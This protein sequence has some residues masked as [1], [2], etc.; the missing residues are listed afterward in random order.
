S[1]PEIDG[2]RG[3]FARL[4]A[5]VKEIRKEKE[6]AGKEVLLL[7]AGDFLGGSP[8][9]WLSL[10]GEAAELKLMQK[11]GYQAAVMGNHEFDYGPELL[12]EYLKEAGYPDAHSDLS[13]LASNLEAPADSLF[14]EDN[15][16]R[17]KRIIE[18]D[19][20]L[21]IGILGIQGENSVSMI[22]D[23][24]DLTF[25]NSVKT[26]QKMTA[27][28][29]K[30][31]DVIIA[32]THSGIREDLKLAREIPALD[33][34]IGGHSHTRLDEVIETDETLIAQAGSKLEYLGQLDL[35]YDLEAEELKL[36]K[37][38]S[39]L[40]ELN[41]E[42][43]ADPEMKT[44]IDDYKDQFNNQIAEITEYQHY[45]EP[46]T[47]SDF[48]IQAGPPLSESPAG[49]FI[50][51][52]M[53][54]KSEEI[55]GENVDIAVKTNGSIRKDIVPGRNGEISF[56]ELAETVGLGRGRDSYPGY[57][58][59][60]AYLNGREVKELLELAVLAEE[61]MGNSSFLQFSGLRYNYDPGA[62]VLTTLPL[63]NQPLPSLEAVEKAEIYNGDGVQDKDGDDYKAIY[64]DQ[65]YK[66]V[67]DSYLID[68]LP[69]VNNLIPQLNIIPKNKKGEPLL[70]DKREQFKIYHSGGREL[71]IWET[72]VDFAA[73]QENEAG[74]AK[75]PAYY[76][77]HQNRINQV[78]INEGDDLSLRG[79][80]LHS[81]P[82]KNPAEND[83]LDLDPLEGYKIA[84]VYEINQLSNLTAGYNYLRAEDKKTGHQEEF[85]LQGVNFNY[86]YN[87]SRLLKAAGYN[88]YF[89]L[90]PKIGSGYYQ[91]EYNLAGTGYQ[92][93]NLAFNLGLKAE[94]LLAANFKLTGELNY[95]FL[96]LDFENENQEQIL[97]KD[98]SGVELSL[99]LLYQF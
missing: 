61:F 41:A 15:L 89:D 12:A 43:A 75:I 62:A 78:K 31:A 26:A 79:G 96:K 29:N 35:S 94:K 27:E 8:F 50:T 82:L 51:D 57:P 10:R 19:N 91:T 97:N 99:G 90:K 45:L 21:K 49:N 1:D 17:E 30:E 7:S 47:E 11:S 72:V 55:T 85:E 66:V 9:S 81:F 39:G 69:Y 38:Q 34:I 84:A 40:L 98:L 63:S 54:L 80:S 83:S 76:Q 65:L 2:T 68:Y 56:Y 64:D 77:N 18:M 22:K 28:L 5:A 6:K 87:L 44:L 58:V 95:R 13:I 67:T 25:A 20:G 70:L 92:D 53:R 4:A 60:S 36:N 24:G 32:L 93:S 48:K 46:V 86:S 16:Y 23:S 71:K 37:E 74:E 42:I 33:L 52:A 3:G 14:R 88:L 73:E 59:I